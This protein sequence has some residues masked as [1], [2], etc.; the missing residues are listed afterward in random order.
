MVFGKNCIQTGSFL[1][2]QIV[3]ANNL[4]LRLVYVLSGTWLN[5]LMHMNLSMKLDLRK[6]FPI[7]TSP[8]CSDQN[9]LLSKEFHFY[10]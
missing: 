7:Q 8:G 9:H 3:I 4:P 10:K 5:Q 1:D 2:T 6:L